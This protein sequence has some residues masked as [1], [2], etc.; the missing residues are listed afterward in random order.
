MERM[1]RDWNK[2][3][4]VW[5]WCPQKVAKN[6][7][8]IALCAISIFHILSVGSQEY[9][10]CELRYNFFSPSFDIKNS[11]L[12]MTV[13][14]QLRT[15]PN[16]VIAHTFGASKHSGFLS[17]MLT[18]TGIFLCVY[19]Y[20]EKVDLSRYAWYPKTKLGVTMRFWEKNNLT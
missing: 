14:L 7:I 3:F 11:K 10:T 1:E 8:R 16:T 13:P 18:D 9:F 12:S 5:R 19:N 15:V 6:S 4:Q 2:F 20:P 17:V